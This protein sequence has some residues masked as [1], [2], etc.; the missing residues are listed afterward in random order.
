MTRILVDPDQLRTLSDR[1][2]QAAAELEHLDAR[3]RSAYGGL[4]WQARRLSVVRERMTRYHGQSQHTQVVQ[5]IRFVLA[6]GVRRLVES[7]PLWQAPIQQFRQLFQCRDRLQ[8]RACI[9]I[10]G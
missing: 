10:F 3:L 1:W 8:Q 4:Q 7:D 6:V 9:W 5:K 2:R